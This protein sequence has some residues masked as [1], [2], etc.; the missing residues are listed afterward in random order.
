MR[1]LSLHA[2]PIG[3]L[4]RSP[5]KAGYSLSALFCTGFFTAE[6]AAVVDCFFSGA[7]FSDV[8]LAD[9][10]GAKSTFSNFLTS[11]LKDFGMVT[12][13]F[14]ASASLIGSYKPPLLTSK[15]SLLAEEI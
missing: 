11:S 13:A 2:V 1:I 3:S 8:S 10:A 12:P 15:R 4:E 14:L 7:V 6:V 9:A 5:S